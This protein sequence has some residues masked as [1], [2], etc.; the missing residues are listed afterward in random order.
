MLLQV[1]TIPWSDAAKIWGPLGVIFVAAITAVF[2]LGKWFKSTMD[3]TIADA[4]AERNAMRQ[5]NESQAS[6]FLESMT[7]RD[8]IMEKGF[9]EVLHE[10]RN[11]PPRR[12]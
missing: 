6:R 1:E 5:L 10:L 2:F 9:D 12:R 8:E 3:G 4:R 11:Q 7:R